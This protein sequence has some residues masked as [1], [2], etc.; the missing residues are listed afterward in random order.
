MKKLKAVKGIIVIL[1]IILQILFVGLFSYALILYK[2]VETFYRISGI[3]ILI[4]L[5]FL[6]SYLLLRSIKKKS[7]KSFIIPVLVTMII[8]AI[9]FA[10]YYYLTKIYNTIN[11]YSTN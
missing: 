5:F 6:F 8:L 9:E 1:L 10:G 4:Y 7:L 3:V 11:N 2:G